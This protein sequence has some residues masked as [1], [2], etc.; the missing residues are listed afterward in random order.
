MACL[1]KQINFKGVFGIP[2]RISGYIMKKVSLCVPCYNEEQNVN[3]AYEKLTEIMKKLPQYDYEIIFED[4]AST[5]STQQQLRH[6]AYKDKHVKVIINTR[7]FG[8][9]R[10]GKNCCFNATGDVIISIAC[11]LQNPVN[12]IPEFLKY[13]EDGY[14]V[15]MGQKIQSKESKVKYFCRKLFYSIISSCS[16][17]PQIPQ[18][19]GFGAIDANVY[20]KVYEMN[21]PNMSIRH[22]LAE[23]GYEIKLIPYTQEIRQ[24]GKSSYNLSRSFDFA[25]TSLVNTSR[26]PI[27]FLTII[28]CFGVLISFILNVIYF[29]F[30]LISGK[31]VINFLTILL[32]IFFI[33]TMQ[34]FFMGLIGEYLSSVLTKVTVRNIVIEKERINFGNESTLKDKCNQK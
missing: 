12:L 10:S 20:Q 25:I 23:L 1:D 21:E 24:Y 14:L 33:G 15:I 22:I 29:A 13:W 32:F 28:G 17:I 27:R 9:S 34:L 2:Q 3:R 4:N 31:N 6:L 5:D 7:N 16:D 11:D 26:F 30:N 19:T 8:P 18:I